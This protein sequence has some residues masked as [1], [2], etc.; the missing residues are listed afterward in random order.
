MLAQEVAHKYATALFLSA[1]ERKVLDAVYDEMKSLQQVIRA[2]RALI[3]F[4]SAPQV[5][6]ETKAKMVRE[7]F[8]ERVNRLLVEF[9]IVLVHKHRVKFL[10]EIIDEFENLYE[11]E[12]GIGRATVTTAVPM[13]DS[14]RS[15]ITSRLATH[16]GKRIL[17]Q[18]KVDRSIIGGMITMHDGEIIDGSVRHSLTV[19][20]DR[21]SH[22]RVH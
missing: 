18:E 21:L 1:R 11:V 3:N 19:L 13:T 4:L 16:T 7:T 5:L 20:R 22:L 14:E 2:D 17:L 9:L 15:S 6:E 10:D 12:R 8:Q